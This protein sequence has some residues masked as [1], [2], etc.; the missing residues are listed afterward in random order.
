MR[1]IEKGKRKRK[2]R[3]E[4]RVEEDGERK[5]QVKLLPLL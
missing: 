3:V 5:Y 4:E 1:E 2:R